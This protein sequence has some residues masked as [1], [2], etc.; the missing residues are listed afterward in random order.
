MLKQAAKVLF[1]IFNNVHI[2]M[3]NVLKDSVTD[4]VKHV[5]SISLNIL[6]E[7]GVITAI[8]IVYRWTFKRHRCFYLI[9]SWEWVFVTTN[10]PV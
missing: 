9:I 10:N 8:S 7:S 1:L 5:C 6:Q 3:H 4:E 2:L